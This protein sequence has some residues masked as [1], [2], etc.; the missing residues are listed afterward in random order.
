MAGSADNTVWLWNGNNGQFMHIFQGHSAAVT[1]GGFT[2][3][4][5]VFFFKF[6]CI[7]LI[8]IFCM[9][10]NVIYKVLNN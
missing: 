5:K 8:Y 4:G 2:P 1:A 6:M 3:D 10:L 7:V 9:K